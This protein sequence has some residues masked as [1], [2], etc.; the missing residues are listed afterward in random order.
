[1]TKLR[2]QTEATKGLAQAWDQLRA[3]I[4]PGIT[5]KQ[6]ARQLG[7]LLKKAGFPKPAFRFIVAAGSNAAQPHHAPTNRI[8]K[9]GEPVKID[10]G[11]RHRGWCTDVTR[12]VF[13]GRPTAFQRKIYLIVL[14]AQ[15]AAARKLKLGA[16]TLLVDATARQLI[17][18]TGFGKYFIHSTGHA[19]GRHIHERPFLSPK[20]RSRLTLRVGDVVTVEPGVYLPGR[21]GIRIEDMYLITR[22]GA[23]CLTIALPKQLTEVTWV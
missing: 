14:K 12:T 23:R 9:S 6:L 1:M 10:F 17:T 13:L 18:Q 5:E 11:V 8:L 4:R 2:A 16:D 15:A 19:V 22:T 3:Y 21:F 20:P 7:L